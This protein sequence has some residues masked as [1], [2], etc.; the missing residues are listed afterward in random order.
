[1][2]TE[3]NFVYSVFGECSSRIELLLLYRILILIR[4]RASDVCSCGLEKAR[5]APILE[6]GR[7]PG[8]EGLG[9]RLSLI[10]RIASVGI[11]PIYKARDKRPNEN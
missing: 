9:G 8:S 10:L 11:R 4:G 6:V 1:M 5:L 2:N 3:Q 7:C